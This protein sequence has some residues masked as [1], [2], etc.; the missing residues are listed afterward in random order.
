M[1]TKQFEIALSTFEKLRAAF[2]GLSMEFDLQPANVDLAV[3]IPIQAGLSFPVFLN[4]QN[5][6]ELCLETSS[7]G[8]SWF[9]CTNPK[10][11]ENYFEAVS[12]LLSGR[13]RILQHW[14]GKRIV[15]AELQRPTSEGWKTVT[16]CSY[17][18]SV[19][20][21]PKMFKVVQNTAS[22]QSG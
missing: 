8:V 20:W 21:P 11:V 2:P 22:V 13:F 17:L 7:L 15:K 14:R 3:D 18:L 4:L 16:G 5:F 9:P 10:K 6:D 12:G 19:P 1:H